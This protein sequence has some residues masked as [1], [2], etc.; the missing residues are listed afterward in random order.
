MTSVV[1]RGSL[2]HSTN[3]AQGGQFSGQCSNT[4]SVPT[5]VCKVG[6]SINLRG[7]WRGAGVGSNLVRDL[8]CCLEE[9][10]DTQGWGGVISQGRVL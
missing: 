8:G 5:S 2:N 1:Y 9:V 7:V 3:M 10:S 6:K 4:Y